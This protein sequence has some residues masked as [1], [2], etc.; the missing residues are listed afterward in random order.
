ACDPEQF[1]EDWPRMCNLDSTL[2]WPA[3]YGS[4][5]EQ[6]DPA[7]VPGTYL[8]DLSYLYMIAVAW[9]SSLGAYFS[10]LDEQLGAS[11][12][13]DRQAEAWRRYNL[14][15]Q[16]LSSAASMQMP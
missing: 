12:D 5:A 6:E 2:Y 14:Q 10:A 7:E 16:C 3:G 8:W 13:T 1:E 4:G 11:G 15:N 9:N